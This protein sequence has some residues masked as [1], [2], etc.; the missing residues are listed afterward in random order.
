MPLMPLVQERLRT[1]NEAPDM[2]RF[3]F[4][5]PAPL[6]AE[7]LTPK[8]KDPT[9]VATAL[10]R[11]VS[12]LRELTDWTAEVIEPALRGLAEHLGWSS[13]DLFMA[14]RVAITG[15]TVTPPLI[16]SMAR[17]GKDRVLARLERA[18]AALA[19]PPPD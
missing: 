8:G 7:Q 16:E 3:F 13:R 5:E 6:R 12:T 14:L 15:R 18:A 9:A 2:L 11:T 4:E 19:D 10:N 1:L 17:L